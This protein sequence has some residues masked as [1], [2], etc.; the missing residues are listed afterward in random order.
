MKLIVRTV[1]ILSAVLMFLTNPVAAGDLAIETYTLPNGLTVMLHPDHTLPQVVVN[2]WYAVGS[3]DE[4]AGRSGFAHL[5]EHLMFMGT[6]RVPGNSYDVIMERGGGAN[7]AS[8]G[9]DRTNYYSWGPSSLLPTLLWLSADQMDGIGRAMTQEK[10]DLQ[11]DVVRNER[12]QNYENTPYGKAWLMIPPAMYPPDHP[13]HH[14]GIG[15]HE[16]LEAATVEDVKGF[17]ATYYVPGNASLVVA[18]DFDPETVRPLIAR[19]FGAI[20]ASELPGHRTAKQVK[21]EREIRRLATDRV[22]SPKIYL[23]WNSP[24]LYADGD[25]EMDLIAAILADGP[26]SRLERRLVHVDRVAREVDAYQSSSMLGSEFYIEIT[27]PGGGDLEQV[28]RVVLEELALLQSEGPTEAELRRVKASQEAYFHRRNE[29]LVRRADSLNNYRFHFGNAD[30]FDRDLARWNAATIGG[31]TTWSRRVFT[32]GRLD[33]RILPLDAAVVGADLDDRPE[34]FPPAAYE[35][36]APDT[37]ILANG[38]PLHVIRRP[39]SGLFSGSLI[40]DGG[41]RLVPENRAGL[42]ALTAT[43]LTAGAGGRDASAFADAVASLGASVDATASWHSVSVNVS[44][45]SSHLDDTLDLF[46]DAVLR[47]GL[48]AADFDRERNLALDAI[49]AR[50]QNPATV[51]FFT[52]R[53]VVYGRDDPRGWPGGGYLDTVAAITHDELVGLHPK[54]LNPANAQFVFVGDFEPG[55]LTAALDRR[56]D[57]WTAGAH[58]VEPLPPPLT[59]SAP[60]R[61]VLVDRPDAPQTFI[62]IGRPLPPPADAEDRVG[63]T[64]LTTLFGGTFTSRLMQ[65]LRERNGYTYGARALVDQSANQ[66]YLFAYSAVQSEVTGAAL[67]EFKR[68]F[69]GL[70]TGNVTTDELET[71]V[72]TVRYELAD[73][74]ATTS[75]LEATLAGFIDDGRP[76]DSVATAYASVD[77]LTLEEVNAIA[78][79]GLVAWDSLLIVLVGDADTVQPQL[80]EAGFPPA[81]LVDMEGN[82]LTPP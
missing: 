82:P 54:L 26:S 74:A 81:E 52:G 20:A 22:E 29:S 32:E 46:A 67:R 31:L 35:P 25:A 53:S 43:M 13:Y 56:F 75:S 18:G 66:H 37:R 79:S 76:L 70:A 4:P 77:L 3:K 50:G 45:L 69:D 5:F 8:T 15:T 14:P 12:R 38:V 17:F 33:L 48:E 34:D 64:C 80:E 30:G 44:G 28:K 59:G 40:V 9:M 49:R 27:V 58:E 16:D 2:V 57:S 63:R 60:G 10:L 65:N 71:A 11:R 23:V 42:A 73:T 55:E 1:S 21:L 24:P 51:A 47:P 61:L 36:T 62:L 19:T 78:R 72:E 68:E 39:G 6:E 7:N 41:E